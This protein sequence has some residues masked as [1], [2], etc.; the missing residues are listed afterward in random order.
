MSEPNVIEQPKA[1]PV[2]AC[3]DLLGGDPDQSYEAAEET[4]AIHEAERC[5]WMVEAQ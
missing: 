1:S 5:Y 2:V 3:S 4:A